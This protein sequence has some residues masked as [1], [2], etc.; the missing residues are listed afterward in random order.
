M[1]QRTVGPAIPV[2]WSAPR[3]IWPALSNSRQLENA[4]LN[5]CPQCP[6]RDARWSP[7][8]HRDCQQVARRTCAHDNIGRPEGQYRLALRD[9]TLDP[10]CRARRIRPGIRA[11]LHDQAA[12]TRHG[13]RAFHDLRVRST[14]WRTSSHLFRTG[15][16]TTVCI[17]LPRHHGTT[18][19]PRRLNFREASASFRPWRN[20]P[21]CRQISRRFGCF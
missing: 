20:R 21:G 13:P 1:I 18:W 5:L 17:Y 19:M 10:A 3:A 16:G 6:G 8:H 11:V 12:G 9:A 14:V 7:N 4:L 2:E 15:Q